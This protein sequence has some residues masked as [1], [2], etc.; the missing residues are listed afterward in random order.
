VYGLQRVRDATSPRVSAGDVAFSTLGFMGLYL[1]VGI[2]FVFL[3]GR[4]VI[5][6]PKTSTE[7]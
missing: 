6:G 5:R 7:H 4:E 3:V 1:V 2:A